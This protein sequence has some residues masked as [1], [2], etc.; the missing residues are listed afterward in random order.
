[1]TFSDF[2]ENKLL[3]HAF[4]N[5][6]YTPP[7]TLY[8]GL[9]T[10][11]PTD[12]GPGAGEVSTTSTGYARQSITP[13]TGFSAASSGSIANTGTISFSAAT[14]SWGTITHF[15]IFDALTGS[16]N[17]LAWGALSASKTVGSGDTASFAAGQLT[18]TLD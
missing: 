12:A 16:T 2:L 8:L 10:S 1:M 13:S 4:R 14:A 11:A 5:T 15:A 18:I 9:F 7:T 17:M 6:A 3:D